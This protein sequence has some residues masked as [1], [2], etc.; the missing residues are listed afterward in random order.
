[1]K[2]KT[3]P[4][5]ALEQQTKLLESLTRSSCVHLSVSLEISGA[6]AAEA[7]HCR[8][9]FLTM[10]QRPP[11]PQEI[12]HGHHWAPLE[13]RRWRLTT[14]EELAEKRPCRGSGPHSTVKCT[15]S[16]TL[17]LVKD[18]NRDGKPY[19]LRFFYCP[20]HS[21]GRWIEGGK[22]YS[23]ALQPDAARTST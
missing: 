1:M 4:F 12:H 8:E 7:R 14:P 16:T 13:A 11:P 20:S 10:I 15:G 18:A 21:L 5:D 23:W 3:R 22:V 6:N 17:C 9:S 19:A 2:W